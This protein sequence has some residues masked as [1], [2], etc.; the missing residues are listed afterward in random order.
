MTDATEPTTP[1]STTPTQPSDTDPPR[2]ASA[3]DKVLA[4]IEKVGNALPEPFTLFLLLFLITGIIST[5]MAW[6]GAEVQVPGSDDIRQIKGLFTKE[7]LAWF[8]VNIGENYVGF[9]PLAYVLPI[10]LAV[11]IAERS[12]MLS[13]LIRSLF[14]SANTVVL[15]Y[16]VGIIGVSAS[17]IADPAFIV[18]PP[19]AAMVFQA[20]GRHPVAGLLGGFASVGAGYAT[21]L[22]PGSLDAL[23][24]GITNSVMES[25]PGIETNEVTV[26]SNYWFNLASASILGFLAGFIIDKILE[27]RL[28]KLGVPDAMVEGDDG[29][30]RDRD[31]NEISA[32]LAPNERRG[33]RATL[34]ATLVLTIIT[35]VAVLVPNSPW[36]NEDGGFLPDSPLMESSVFLV[37]MYFVVM[38]L[39]Y[40]AAAGTVKS[41]TDMTD[42]MGEAMK[43]MIGFLILAFILG[44]FI[45]LFN[46]SGIGTFTA[47]KGAQAL[48]SAGISGFGAI[49]AFVVLASCLNLLIIS[50]S[51]LWTLMASVFVPMFA[52]LGFDPAFVQAA[53]RVGDSATQIITPLNPYIIVV[54][55]QLRRYEPKA[56][57]G[58]LM[59]RL[60][61]FTVPFWLFWL[62]LLFVWYQFD[63]PLGPGSSI[64]L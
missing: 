16:A 42:M 41:V 49:V 48:E 17:L 33:L 60:I 27:P 18:I 40:G 4:G 34:W 47:V 38:G 9:P 8:T 20:A 44:Q 51:A 2:R 21:S 14:G 7:G 19:L 52:L 64:F 50:G 6:A 31:G 63:L 61:V 3:T 26:V 30:S 39:A 11:G 1:T 46:W 55:S 22:L 24:A 36:R 25:L 43:D 57:V 53:Y 54:L 5:A 45:A 23:F 37:V 35:V 32:E 28:R 29:M 10:I 13:A 62:A 12:G 59:S 56:G 15:P 58:T